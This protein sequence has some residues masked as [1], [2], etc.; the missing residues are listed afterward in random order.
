MNWRRVCTGDKMSTFVVENRI[1]DPA[2]Q[3]PRQERK[4]LQLARLRETV[5]RAMRVPF[6]ER[7]FEKE[8]ITPAKI[9]SLDDLRRLPFTTKADMRENY[10]LGLCAVPRAELARI[11][12]SSGTTGVP[13]FVG[14]TKKDLQTWAGLCARFLVAG[15]LRPEHTVQV[16]FGYG[17]FTGGFGLHYGIEA[18]GAAIIPAASGNTPRQIMLMRDLEPDV[19]ICTPSYALNVAEVMLSTGMDPHTM[20]VKYAHFGGEMWTEDLRVEIE[21]QTGI[22]AFNNY[23]LSEIIGPG[24]S[25]ECAVRE[26]MHLQE[27][28]FLVECLD[29]ETLE[30]VEE[31]AYGEL[32]ITALTREAMPMIRYRTRDIAAIDAC[33]CE[34][35]RTTRRMSRV[36]G[37][38]DDMLIIR[39]VN[40]FPS[41]IEEALLGVEGTTPHYL[42]EV[43][44]PGALDEVT[45]KVEVNTAFFSDKMSE[46]QDLRDRIDR[47]IQGY[48]GIHV[49]VELVG[50]KTIERSVG[51]ALR[52]VDHRAMRQ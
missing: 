19:L 14:Y 28:H 36:M 6:Y 31:G 26:G 3:M 24:V 23:G 8:G 25:G 41:Q 1:W 12:G 17:L 15:G 45:V 33:L 2:E 18:V 29:P 30:P 50:P 35:G 11:H 13:T 20:S 7:A 44:R 39:G 42:I 47:K 10:P 51:K 52:V 37:R 16:A 34:C 22:L 32:V 4:A 21:N 27:D 46:M 38:S 48:T 5:E 43:D 40:V 49:K 9:K